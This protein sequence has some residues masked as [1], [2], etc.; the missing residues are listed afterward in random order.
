MK[1]VLFLTY[2]VSLSDWLSQKILERELSLYKAYQDTGF[3][4]SVVSYGDRRDLI[5]AR[6]Y[7]FSG[8]FVNVWGLPNRVY[9]WLIPFIFRSEL[10]SSHILKTNQ[11]KG[12]HV[13]RRCARFFNKPLVVRQGYSYYEFVKARRPLFPT[14]ASWARLYEKKNLSLA[15]AVICTTKETATAF[16]SRYDLNSK[17]IFVVPNFVL[18]DVWSPPFQIRESVG[19]L[20]LSFCGRLTKQKNLKTLVDSVAGLNVK[21]TFIGAGKEG[22]SLL[23][24]AKD[25]GV[26]LCLAGQLPQKEV[27]KLLKKC[28]A[29][30]LPSYYEGH[31]K[32]LIEAMMLGMP[33]IGADSPGIRG[34][35]EDGVTG[36]LAKPTKE[37][38]RGGVIRMIDSP[39]RTRAL[40][41]ANARR[42][43]Q[44]LYSLSVI[45]EKETA[46]VHQAW[47]RHQMLATD[48]ER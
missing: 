30:I 35:I 11:M 38:L 29:F 3:D 22:L 43:A 12:A 4:V 24:R 9:S 2:G 33:V 18:D 5:L 28:D 23:E 27:A 14:A 21:L 32:A 41:G 13:A 31:P 36:F 6:K 45:A 37:G 47:R 19:P 42:K 39:L 7:G 20:Q 40:M 1:V 46:I 17:R 44:T 48:Y 34:E 25:L 16:L 8:V 26:D 10:R 15:D